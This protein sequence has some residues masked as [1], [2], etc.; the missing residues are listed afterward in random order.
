MKYGEEITSKLEEIATSK[1]KS[2]KEWEYFKKQVLHSYMIA[3]KI[4]NRNVNI[5][6][7]ENW[8]ER[9]IRL[10]F[11]ERKLDRGKE[12]KESLRDCIKYDIENSDKDKDESQSKVLLESAIQKN[13]EQLYMNTG[14]IPIG[15]KKDEHGKIV[16]IAPK[17]TIDERANRLS[18][19]KD[20]LSVS[21]NNKKQKQQITR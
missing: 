13:A 3:E 15:Y 5:E 12:Q 1:I 10:G 9:L 7:H 14:I 8:E 6:E 18:A 11:I 4:G 20:N 19:T 16:R 2:P 17:I 21:E